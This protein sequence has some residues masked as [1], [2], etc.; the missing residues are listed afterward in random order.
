VRISLLSLTVHTVGL[1]HLYRRKFSGD[2]YFSFSQRFVDVCEGRVPRGSMTLMKEISLAKTTT[3]GQY[4][5]YK[6]Q[7]IAWDDVMS[8]YILHPKVSSR[9]TLW[10]YIRRTVV[11]IYTCHLILLVYLNVE[12]YKGVD[13]YEEENSVEHYA[14]QRATRQGSWTLILSFN[15]DTDTQNILLCPLLL[16]IDAT[17]LSMNLPTVK[18]MF[19]IVLHTIIETI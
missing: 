11:I 5:Y 18:Q 19:P 15:L 7:D 3:A 6:L 2:F 4:L 9:M 1:L 8:E 14:N 13:M 16:L 10:N 17:S 12:V